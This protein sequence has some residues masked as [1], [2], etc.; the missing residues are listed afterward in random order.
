MEEIIRKKVN[1][2]GWGVIEG[3]FVRGE[4]GWFCREANG[5]R[6]DFLNWGAPDAMDTPAEAA[7]YLLM[8]DVDD[9]PDE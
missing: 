4:R 9:P 2:E 5:V 8:L 1:I 6:W 3:Q 7:E